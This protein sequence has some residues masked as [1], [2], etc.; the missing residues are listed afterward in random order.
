VLSASPPLTV[1]MPVY[2]GERYVAEAIESI[3]G[4]THA[5]FELVISDN[6]STDATEEICR[7][8]AARDDRISYSRLNHN[9][10]AA[11]NYNRVFE[12]NRSPLFKFASHDDVCLP[13]FLEVC[14]DAYKEAP[15]D[16]VLCFPATIE[17]DASGTRGD[18]LVD[19]LDLRQPEPHQRFRALLRGFH[20]ANCLFGVL[21]ASAY[22]STR[23]VE[24]YD[25]SD[26]VLL[27]E[28][29]LRGQFQ[30]LD[31]PLFL[32][33][34]H[35]EM[36]R[37]ANRTTAD[38]IQW[39]DPS[40]SAKRSFRRFRM[41]KEFLRAIDLAPLSRA[42]RMRCRKEFVAAWLPKYWKS[43]VLEATNGVASLAPRR[44]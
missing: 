39:F 3:L 44:S 35:K 15:E 19:N 31:E 28:L 1:G 36:S 41:T 11:Y 4:Q 12:L 7:S 38:V 2:N 27:G 17:I 42:E 33:R 30:Q 13:R 29:A 34:F 21:R 22:R 26:V 9:R 14:L 43:M 25:S 20:L 24:P 37:E 16:T 8:Y 18:R 40:K 32:R 23:L 6:C 10:G 5:D